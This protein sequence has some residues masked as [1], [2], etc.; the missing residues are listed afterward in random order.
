M[1]EVS[2]NISKTNN[3]EPKFLSELQVIFSQHKPWKCNDRRYFIVRFVVQRLN[4]ILEQKKNFQFKYF[5]KE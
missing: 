4:I 1:Y 3:Y 2:F 5:N